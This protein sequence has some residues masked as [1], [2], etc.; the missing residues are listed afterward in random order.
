MKT[1]LKNQFQNK[2]I[3][4]IDNLPFQNSALKEKF[5]DLLKTNDA[6]MKLP[7]PNYD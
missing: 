4:Y 2:Y 7:K 5:I 1:L 6:M 3:S